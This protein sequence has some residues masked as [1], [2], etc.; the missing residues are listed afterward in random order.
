MIRFIRI[1]IYGNTFKNSLR[2]RGSKVIFIT[3]KI[4]SASYIVLNRYLLKVEM[5][6]GHAHKTR[7]WYLFGV[8]SKISDKHPRHFYR[9]LPPSPPPPF[10]SEKPALIMTEQQRCTLYNSPDL[11]ER[12]LY[13]IGVTTLL[14]DL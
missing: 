7:F 1:K 10:R 9:R 8:S 4:C 5:N 11:P 12:N 2:R 14:K 13:I 6:L 3:I